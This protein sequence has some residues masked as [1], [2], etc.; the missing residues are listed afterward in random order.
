MID[1][2]V[3]DEITRF[4]AAIAR[5][6]DAS[7]SDDSVEMNTN[8]GNKLKRKARTVHEGSLGIGYRNE[9]TTHFVQYANK[10]RAVATLKSSYLGPRGNDEDED[11][12][13]DADEGNDDVDSNRELDDPYH[14]IDIEALLSPITHP[15]ELPSHPGISKAYTRTTIATLARRAL[16]L[17][18]TEQKQLSQINRLLA[19]FLGDSPMYMRDGNL[20]LPELFDH[21]GQELLNIHMNGVETK[22]ETSQS[23]GTSRSDGK[24]IKDEP[25]TKSGTLNGTADDDVDDEYADGEDSNRAITRR[26]TR[27]QTTNELEPFFALPRIEIDRNFGFSPEVAQETRQ[28]A[29]IASKRS[30]EFIRS[31][32]RIRAGLL[33]ADR[34]RGKVYK[35]CREV[36][37]DM[38]EDEEP[39]KQS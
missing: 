32:Y 13:E 30:E 33:R 17:I 19:A 29:Q 1:Q 21:D 36:G 23:N 12:D 38:S 4:K 20:N 28:L 37:G 18:C 14:G 10:R 25:G 6:G 22:D 5:Q 3:L 34:F 9:M 31:L 8:R 35:W 7:D 11:E 16:D 39:T 15:S 24:K 2:H 27:N 26:I